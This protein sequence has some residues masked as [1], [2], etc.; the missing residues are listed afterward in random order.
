MTYNARLVGR[1]VW[2]DRW[3]I[4]IPAASL[5]ADNDRAKAAFLDSVRDIH[6]NLKTYSLSGN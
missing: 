5:N 6:L 3:W 1:S 4:F 2:N